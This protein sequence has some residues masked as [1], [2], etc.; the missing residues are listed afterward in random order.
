[1]KTVDTSKIAGINTKLMSAYEYYRNRLVCSRIK[2]Y[3]FDKPNK[4]LLKYRS[5]QFTN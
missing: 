2:K 1:M 3:R 5:P 4:G